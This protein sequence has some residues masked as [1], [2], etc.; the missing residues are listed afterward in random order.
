M[1]GN[2]AVHCSQETWLCASL[3]VHSFSTS[4]LPHCRGFSIN[5]K[6]MKEPSWRNEQSVDQPSDLSTIFPGVCC[7]IVPC[8][9]LS[10]CSVLEFAFSFFFF[11]RIFVWLFLHLT[12]FVKVFTFYPF[13]WLYFLLTLVLCWSQCYFINICILKQAG[14]GSILRRQLKCAANLLISK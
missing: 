6:G 5:G 10:Q 8:L 9:Q 4:S 12:I 14:F 1:L 13:K 2:F 7:F 3:G 11:L